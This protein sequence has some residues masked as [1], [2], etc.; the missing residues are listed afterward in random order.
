MCQRERSIRFLASS[1][2]NWQN[3]I[4]N[5]D[6][7]NCANSQA[8]GELR[9][10]MKVR[11]ILQPKHCNLVAGVMTQQVTNTC[12]CY[13]HS[14]SVTNLHIAK[15]TTSNSSSRGS[16]ILFLPPMNRTHMVHLHIV[17]QNI[18]THNIKISGNFWSITGLSI[19]D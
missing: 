13:N 15:S 19:S 9:S 6:R 12:C 8:M 5:T 16:D 2:L 18:N 4:K 17:M 11:E 7:I 14:I 3:K 10:Q 1:L